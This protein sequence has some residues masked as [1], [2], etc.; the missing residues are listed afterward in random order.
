MMTGPP[1][2]GSG[3]A[4]TV[5]AA[6]HGGALNGG[7]RL[8]WREAHK[9]L[10]SDI[11]AN[12]KL[13]STLRE[14]ANESSCFVANPGNLGDGLIQLGTCDLFA[15]IGWSP[16]CLLGISA[17]HFRDRQIAVVGGGGGWIEGLWEEWA[18]CLKG[19]LEAGGR[20][21]LLS[22]SIM[23]FEEYFRRHAEQVTLFVRETRSFER[24]ASVSELQHR[25]HLCH[26]LAFAND[27]MTFAEFDKS[28][29]NGTLHLFRKDGESRG[30][31]IPADN[32]DLA[33]LWNGVQWG[34]RGSC[35]PPLMAAA[36]LIA[37]FGNVETDR[38]HMSVLAAMVGCQVRMHSNNYFKNEGV[39][40]MSLHRFENVVLKGNEIPSSSVR[41]SSGAS[42]EPDEMVVRA[43]ESDG[44]RDE[45]VRLARLRREYFEPEIIRLNRVIAEYEKTKREWFEPELSRLTKAA[46]DAAAALAESQEAAQASER[47]VAEHFEPEIVRLNGVIAEYEKTK[48]EWFEPELQRLTKAADAAAS[49]SVKSQEAAQ[50]TEQRI[51]E[52]FEPEFARLLAVVEKGLH[53]RKALVRD[54]QD[55]RARVFYYIDQVA[56]LASQIDPL[57]ARVK[58]LEALKSDWFDPE[59]HRMHAAIEAY[60]KMKREW[61]EPQL[62]QRQA[63]LAE[64]EARLASVS[65]FEGSRSYRAWRRLARLLARIGVKRYREL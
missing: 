44:L 53:E 56:M 51:A 15:Q 31:P 2:R 49:A 46:E 24:L 37:Q 50:A 13:I 33:L 42:G 30:F 32:I 21:I 25:V 20:L 65:Q 48:C 52:H 47:R 55:Q 14:A 39:Y 63:R 34:D 7:L 61:F 22:S 43:P 10:R 62:D 18:R 45:L 12:E 27:P 5:E 17:E 9:T 28:H 11:L 40:D 8:P 19:Y 35:L 64:L 59:F 41:V 4:W 58:E 16:S 26:D 23:G 29:A 57:R 54:V 36:K 1:D 60:E 3:N 38:L 6:S